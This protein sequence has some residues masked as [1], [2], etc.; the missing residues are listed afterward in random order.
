LLERISDLPES[1]VQQMIQ[2]IRMEGRS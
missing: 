2:E 1:R